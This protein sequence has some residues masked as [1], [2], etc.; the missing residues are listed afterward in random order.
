MHNSSFVSWPSHGTSSKN[1]GPLP[2]GIPLSNKSSVPL[3]GNPSWLQVTFASLMLNFVRQT[4]PHARLKQISSLPSSGFEPFT[5]LMSQS[6]QEAS[7]VL[8]GSVDKLYT[9]CNQ[10]EWV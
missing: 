3:K 7:L 4:V 8:R 1:I 6:V 5:S 2:G 10:N 9:H